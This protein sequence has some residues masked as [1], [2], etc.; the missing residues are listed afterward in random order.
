MFEEGNAHAVL[1]VHPD[2]GWREVR[3]AYWALARRY[4]PDGTEPDAARM[5]AINAAYE[6]LERE[7]RRP[8][9]GTGRGVP[10]GPGFS[11]TWASRSTAGD[12]P[13]PMAAPDLGPLMR[14]V[15]DA[16]YGDTPV[17]DFGQYA[18]WRI[19]D[20]ARHD[21]A[22]L[23]WLSRHSSGLRYRSA[24]SRVLG[25]DQSVGRRGAVVD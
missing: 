13:Q 24:I 7:C 25:G 15:A 5:A 6:E 10:V 1:R 23:R 4:H 16:Q 11:A 3:Q 14:R 21:P 18:G 22:Y 8:S 2:A 20:V 12:G 17:I 19:A 9:R